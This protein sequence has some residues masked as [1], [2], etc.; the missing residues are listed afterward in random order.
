[1]LP[2]QKTPPNLCRVLT[3]VVLGRSV[4]LL[5]PKHVFAGKETHMRWLG[6]GVGLVFLSVVAIYSL[7]I[8]LPSTYSVTVTRTFDASSDAV[9]TKINDYEAHP[10]SGRMARQITNLP[11]DPDQPAWVEDIGSSKITLTTLDQE[12]GSFLHRQAFDSVVPMNAVIKIRMSREGDQTTVSITNQTTVRQGTWQVP[13]FRLSLY[14]TNSLETGIVDYLK[15]I[16]DD[17]NNK[18]VAPKS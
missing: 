13:L 17:L 12:P 6:I 3:E 4:N 14:F 2:N 16:E 10:V 5:S 7:G 8:F 18:T 15:A 11:S 9:W 1:M